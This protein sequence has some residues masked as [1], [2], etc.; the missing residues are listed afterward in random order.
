M[1]NN[2]ST[3]QNKS[4]AVIAQ[5]NNQAKLAFSQSVSDII[6]NQKL[7]FKLTANNNQ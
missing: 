7:H 2:I 5:Q 6:N 1:S 3:I 4:N